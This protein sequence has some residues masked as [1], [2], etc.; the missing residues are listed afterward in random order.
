MK[1]KAVGLRYEELNGEG[2]KSEVLKAEEFK[3]EDS[4]LRA[5]NR[6]LKAEVSTPG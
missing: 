2:L 5:K 6:G 4:K 3:A 1:I